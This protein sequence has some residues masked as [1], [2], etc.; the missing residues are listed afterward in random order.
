MFKKLFAVFA[1]LTLVGLVVTGPAN[2]DYPPTP[3][4]VT[5]SNQTPGVGV[6]VTV[7]FKDGT[8]SAGETVSILIEGTTEIDVTLSSSVAQ[9]SAV[10]FDY[11]KEA[12]TRT[13]NSSGGVSLKVAFNKPGKYTVTGTGQ[14]SG[15]NAISPV[16]TVGG[17]G[18]NPTPAP[19]P[20]HPQT[21]GISALPLVAGIGLLAIGGTAILVSRRRKSH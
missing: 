6:P 17:G 5:V 20:N 10:S 1:G 16:I 7:G 8:F 13:A 14:T 11:S 4:S 18:D 21:G 9:K 19:G 3:D 2:A 12:G 15:N